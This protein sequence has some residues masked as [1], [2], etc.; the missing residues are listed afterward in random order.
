MGYVYTASSSGS[1]SLYGGNTNLGGGII[2]GGGNGNADIR[3]L[4]QASTATPAERLRMRSDGQIDVKYG[5]I[6]L[7]TADVSSGHIN[8]YELMTFNADSDNDDSNRH[9]TWYKNAASG[10]GT[11]MMRL[12]ENGRLCVGG[13]CY[14]W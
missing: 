13:I 10:A 2:L 11:G 8:A 6:N 5:V 14:F 7:G 9:F 3:F 12:D 4:A 1:L